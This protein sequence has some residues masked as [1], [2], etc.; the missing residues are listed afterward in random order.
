MRVH[1][2]SAAPPARLA[3]AAPG[4][5]NRARHLASHR[6]HAGIVDANYLRFAFLRGGEAINPALQK[7]AIC[8]TPLVIAVVA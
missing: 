1:D 8:L 4:G 6:G 5:V 7:S 2:Q 3:Q